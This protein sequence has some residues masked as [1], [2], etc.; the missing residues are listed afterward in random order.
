MTRLTHHTYPCFCVMSCLYARNSS[1]PAGSGDRSQTVVLDLGPRLLVHRAKGNHALHCRPSSPGQRQDQ[2]CRHPTGVV[3][4]LPANDLLGSMDMA[5]PDQH[6]SAGI[7][8]SRDCRKPMLGKA[9]LLSARAAAIDLE[10]MLR[11]RPIGHPMAKIAGAAM[12][13]TYRD[14][15]GCP[16]G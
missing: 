15:G 13:A 3:P 14:T 16:H 9:S 7:C 2:L 5:R 1:S 12:Q 11:D 10:R 6:R 8:I 4:S